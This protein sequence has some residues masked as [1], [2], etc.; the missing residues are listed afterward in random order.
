[1]NRSSPSISAVRFSPARALDVQTGLLG[2]VSCSIDDLFELDGIAL[3]RTALGE[4]RLSFP[5]RT[6]STG[7]RHPLLRPL[8]AAAWRT[9]QAQVFTAL[10]N[11]GVMS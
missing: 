2:Y 11:Q 8:H 1:V 6:D 5:M 10:R 7:R 3:R 9:M 4:L